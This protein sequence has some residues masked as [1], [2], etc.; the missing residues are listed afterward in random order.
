MSQYGPD[1][2]FQGHVWST[3]DYFYFYF[4]KG[5]P[6]LPCF[7]FVCVAGG[8]CVCV[9]EYLCVVDSLSDVCVQKVLS[10][11]AK[12]R[13]PHINNRS[14]THRN[15]R[16]H[17][18]KKMI[19][20]KLFFKKKEMSIQPA[21]VKQFFEKKGVCNGQPLFHLRCLVLEQHHQWACTP[22]VFVVELD[23]LFLLHS[24]V[25]SG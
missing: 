25:A 3:S 12:R 7:C 20:Q 4:L 11:H 21:P 17:T 16:P 14:H 24:M 18:K 23:N 22:T 10:T 9:A 1:L 13:P 8:L 15:R 6:F 5:V 2:S 19:P